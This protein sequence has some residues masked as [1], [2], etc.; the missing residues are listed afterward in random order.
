L[1]QSLLQA[2]IYVAMIAEEGSF[3]RAARKLRT[4]QSSLSRRIAELEK[5]LEVKLFERSTRKLELTAVGKIVLPEIQLALR[6]SQ[7]AWEL[8]RY[9][10]R[11]RNGPFRIGCSSSSSLSLP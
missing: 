9:W 10:G 6:H 4:S 7:R 8:A 1:D 11:I 3:S 2:Q 5:T